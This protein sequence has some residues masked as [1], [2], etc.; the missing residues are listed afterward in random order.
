MQAINCAY[1]QYKQRVA[2][3]KAKILLYDALNI[4]K[5]ILN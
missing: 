3:L 1:E 2:L 4:Q 5:P